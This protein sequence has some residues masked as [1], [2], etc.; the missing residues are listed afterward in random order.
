MIAESGAEVAVAFRTLDGRTEVLIDEDKEFH[1]A[2]TMKVPVMVE[3]FRQ[4]AAGTLSLD[5]RVKVVNEF[6]SV[7]DGSPYSLSVGD[8]SDADI[9]AAVGTER[10]YRELCEAMITIS[11]NL[12]TNLLIDRLGA[13]AVHQ[14]MVQYG[15]G[16]MHVRRGVEDG[17]AFQAGLNN[18]A[19]ARAYAAI[20][21]AIARGETVSPGASAE[22]IEILKRQKFRAGIPAGV[23]ADVAVGN[24]TGTITKI[25]HDGAIVLGPRPYVLVV[26]TRGFADEKTSDQLIARISRAVHESLR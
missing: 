8:D 21:R 11:S 24:K 7:V 16:G 6:R 14:T 22:M 26:L 10:T 18:T 1:A 13:E 12:A 23:P 19:T 20:L 17:K 2:S 15:A 3:L 9:Y 4:A 25:H 5:D